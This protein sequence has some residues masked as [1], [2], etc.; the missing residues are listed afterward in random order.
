MT[1]PGKFVW[2][3]EDSGNK[4]CAQGFNGDVLTLDGN[5]VEGKTADISIEE[6]QTISRGK[7]K[8]IRKLFLI[9]WNYK[10][11][12][13]SWDGKSLELVLD[14]IKMI[15]RKKEQEIKGKPT[16]NFEEETLK[17]RKLKTL[18]KA[19]KSSDPYAVLQIEC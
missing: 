15:V 12:W 5:V 10:K 11:Y 16:R 8:R 1:Q 6:K 18:E 2:L 17:A 13:P 9:Y 7:K 4:F 19:C 14:A 3:I